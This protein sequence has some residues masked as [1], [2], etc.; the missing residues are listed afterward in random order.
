MRCKQEQEKNT[1][2]RQ[3]KQDVANVHLEEGAKSPKLNVIGKSD[4]DEL[5]QKG[6]M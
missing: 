6:E 4:P 2:I 3:E 1:Q 5:H